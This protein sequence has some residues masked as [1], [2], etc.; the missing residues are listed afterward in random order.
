MAN[1][2]QP[3]LMRSTSSTVSQPKL[4][5][6]LS[7]SQPFSIARSTS[8]RS[9]NLSGTL[10]KPQKECASTQALRRRVF[11]CPTP[12]N[13]AHCI[14]PYAKVYGQHPNLFEFNR[15]GEMQLTDAGIVAEMQQQDNGLQV[16]GA[17]VA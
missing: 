8:G 14:T 10:Q 13:T 15:K 12:S 5:S 16:S 4:T 6:T 17:G 1:G 3:Q 9:G 11:F 7:G 2:N